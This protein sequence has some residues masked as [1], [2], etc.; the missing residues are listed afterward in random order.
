MPGSPGH[1]RSV[2]GTERTRRENSVKTR[3][4]SKALSK[5]PISGHPSGH[6]KVGQAKIGNQTECLGNQN[7]GDRCLKRSRNILDPL[8][9]RKPG[10]MR[11]SF[12]V[13]DVPR[14]TR[15]PIPLVNDSTFDTRKGKVIA[16]TDGIQ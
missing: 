4:L 9:R 6:S 16:L 11:D 12:M 1:H 5:I 8:S 2:I 15:K 10:S 7:V 3:F 14:P 13:N